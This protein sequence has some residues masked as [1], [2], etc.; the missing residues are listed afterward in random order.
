MKQNSI[1]FEEMKR[2]AKRSK[3]FWR[4]LVA[5]IRRKRDQAI[6]D[7]KKYEK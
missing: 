6:E 5:D 3:Q 4:L 7:L 1:D 2:E